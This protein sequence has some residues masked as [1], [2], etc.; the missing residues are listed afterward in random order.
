MRRAKNP[1]REYHWGFESL[2]QR[3]YN[4]GRYANRMKQAV[5]KT[6]ALG[7]VGSS[8]TL[9]TIRRSPS[10]GGGAAPK[11]AG[12]LYRLAGST[13]VCGAQTTSACTDNSSYSVQDIQKRKIK[14][15]IASLVQQ[16][17]NFR[18]RRKARHCSHPCHCNGCSMTGK[19]Q[20]FTGRKSCGKN[21]TEGCDEGISSSSGI[22]NRRHFYTRCVMYTVFPNSHRAVSPMVMIR[23]FTPRF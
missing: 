20:R 1:G 16:F 19:I 12:R 11:A 9:P 17:L 18:N 6:V 13:P 10:N 8:P 14:V 2:S 23:F 15:C 4:I 3:S 7:L 21:R 5:C 22:C